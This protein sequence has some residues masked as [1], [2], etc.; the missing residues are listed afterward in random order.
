MFH[1]IPSWA[2]WVRSTAS[3]HMCSW[4]ST[5]ILWS[6]PWH[7]FS[8]WSRYEMLIWLFSC[9]LRYCWWCS[10][11]VHVFR[12]IVCSLSPPNPQRRTKMSV[13]YV[14]HIVHC[15]LHFHCTLY[16]KKIEFCRNPRD[17][18]KR[19][20]IA[21]GNAILCMQYVTVCMFLTFG[22]RL[23]REYNKI[24]AAISFQHTT[25]ECRDRINRRMNSAVLYSLTLTL[26][27]ARNFTSQN[28]YSLL[29]FQI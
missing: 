4:S 6:C 17:Y 29:C 7:E 25:L 23:W 24:V 22:S 3:R 21:V 10:H 26:T 20:E 19:Q 11:T 1:W 16:L 2:S 18:V 9:C 13:F 8:R 27:S 15:W 28:E 14:K 5:L 12:P